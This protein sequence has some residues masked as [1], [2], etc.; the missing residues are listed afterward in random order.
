M[1]LYSVVRNAG[2]FVIRSM[3]QYRW[4]ISIIYRE[5]LVVTVVVG[6]D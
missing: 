6:S 1:V 3:V 4:N 2:Y 5:Y